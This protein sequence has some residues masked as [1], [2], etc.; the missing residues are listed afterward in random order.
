[1]RP[2]HKRLNRIFLAACFATVNCAGSPTSSVP[3]KPDDDLAKIVSQ[4][5]P[6]TTFRLAPGI[7]RLQTVAP[8]DGQR[9]IGEKGTIFNGA[10]VLDN[11]VRKD[12]H[13][14]HAGLP[15]SLQPHGYCHKKTQACMYRED[16][17][18]DGTVLGRV[19]ERKDLKPG[20]WFYKDKIAYLA[21]DPTGHTVELGVTPLAFGGA[22]K[23]VVLENFAI[24]K[25]ASPAQVGAVD[26]RDAEG[27]RLIGMSIRWN[28]GVGLFIGPRTRVEGGAYNHNGQ[29]GIAGIGDNTVIDGAEIAFNNYADFHQQWEAGGFKF[30]NSKGLV[31]RNSCVHDNDGVGMWNDINNIDTLFENNRVFD[32][33]GIGIAQEISY[34]ATIRNNIVARNGTSGDD[35]LWGAQILIQNSQNVDVYG[36]T[37]E[38]LPGAGNGI[39]I[40]YQKRGEG[41]YGPFLAQNNRIHGNV[42][43]H[44]GDHGVTGLVADFDKQWFRTKSNNMFDANK[45]IVPTAHRPYWFAYEGYQDLGEVRKVGFERN[46][47]LEQRKL[48][49]LVI[50]CGK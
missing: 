24:E 23:G 41:R 16:L 2:L 6:H 13:W 42:I 40:I 48:K 3:I 47:T 26:L 21:D 45:Y 28:H 8:K 15:P 29:M 1:M 9:F 25:Y 11:W 5:P 12:S 22:A 4:Y 33:A 32:N 31:V 17:F 27:W 44:L 10:M 46:G 38:V 50:S 37:V 39:G 7:Y 34:A 19:L 36:N 30:V 14:E 35:W 49:P 20:H 43:R 18:I